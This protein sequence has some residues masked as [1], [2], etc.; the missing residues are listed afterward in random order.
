MIELECL[1]C[2]HKWVPRRSRHLALILCPKCLS[3]DI[4]MRVRGVRA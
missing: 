3:P 1:N 4:F 2:G